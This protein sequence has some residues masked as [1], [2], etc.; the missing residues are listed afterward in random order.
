MRFAHFSRIS[1]FVRGERPAAA[2]GRG[3]IVSGRGLESPRVVHPVQFPYS[4]VGS[5][6]GGDQPTANGGQQQQRVG[7]DEHFDDGRRR[8]RLARALVE[9]TIPASVLSPRRRAYETRDGAGSERGMLFTATTTTGPPPIPPLDNRTRANATDAPGKTTCTPSRPF[10]PTLW[11]SPSI[12]RSAV[13][14]CDSLLARARHA[15]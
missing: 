1:R 5:F 2:T 12:A 8:R 11:V 9:R 6:S 4:T 10:R 14:C 7:G 15:F 13:L 3:D